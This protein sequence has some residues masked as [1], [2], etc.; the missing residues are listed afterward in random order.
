MYCCGRSGGPPHPHLR[1]EK[2]T[3]KGGKK[4]KGRF[5]RRG[6]KKPPGKASLGSFTTGEG[7]Y[8]KREGETILLWSVIKNGKLKCAGGKRKPVA[9]AGIE[10]ERT[11]GP[12]EGRRKE[13]S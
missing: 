10:A 3:G 4:K 9:P 7:A 6:E 12:K 5:I 2:K 8:E 11:R 1:K 13:K